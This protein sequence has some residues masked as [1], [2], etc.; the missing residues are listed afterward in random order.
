MRADRRTYVRQPL[1]RLTNK[2]CIT[3]ASVESHKCEALFFTGPGFD[4]VPRNQCPAVNHR[5]SHCIPNNA[6][7]VPDNLLGS[8]FSNLKLSAYQHALLFIFIFGTR[9][10]ISLKTS[11]RLREAIFIVRNFFDDG[12]PDNAEARLHSN[13]P[14]RMT[15]SPVTYVTNSS[16]IRKRLSVS[17][18]IN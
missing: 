13:Q 6:G 10:D 1:N 17:I 8:R 5:S 7:T 2:A 9:R 4:S 3:Y 18:H 12:R 11:S 16:A 15:I 14:R